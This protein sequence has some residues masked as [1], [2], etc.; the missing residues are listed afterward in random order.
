MLYQDERLMRKNKHRSAYHRYIVRQGR[1]NNCKE[2]VLVNFEISLVVIVTTQC[3]DSREA[4]TK[5]GQA[6]SV[7]RHNVISNIYFVEFSISMLENSGKLE[8][9]KTK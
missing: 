3:T 9:S 2:F 7:L 6:V 1:V 5:K 8:N 4:H